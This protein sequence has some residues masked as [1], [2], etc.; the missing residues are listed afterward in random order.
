MLST[1]PLL[2]A[3]ACA[4]SGPSAHLATP[5]VRAPAATAAPS[6]YMAGWNDPYDG[7]RSERGKLEVRAAVSFFDEATGGFHG[8]TCSS[9]PES[10]EPPA[11]GAPAATLDVQHDVYFHTRV[12]DPRCL[13]VIELVWVEREGRAVVRETSGG[14][15]AFPLLPRSPDSGR[16]EEPSGKAARARPPD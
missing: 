2:F 4:F 13:V 15:A 14:W 12:A 16:A 10:V 11:P 5:L 3:A 8:A 1:A 6:V 9:V 7:G